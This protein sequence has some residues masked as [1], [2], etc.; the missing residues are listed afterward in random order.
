VTIDPARALV[1]A[2][3]I[4][5]YEYGGGMDL[6]GAATEASRFARW[7]R[8]CGVPRDRVLLACS[9]VDGQPAGVD[10]VERIGTTRREMED[11]IRH[12]G[13]QTGDLLLIFWCGHGVLTEEG[14]RALFT[15]DAVAVNKRNVVVDDLLLSLASNL[16]TGFGRQIVLIDA[17]ANFI[18]D[19]HFDNA[20][21]PGTL[22]KGNL[23]RDVEQFCY[24]SAAQGQIADFNRTERQATFSNAVLN[25]LET[26]SPQA[27]P[28]DVTA[29][30]RHIDDLFENLRDT[31]RDLRQRPVYRQVRHY[32]GSEDIIAPVSVLPVAGQ[33]Q[34]VLRAADMTVSQVHR[35]VQAIVSLPALD[36]SDGRH[37]FVAGLPGDIDRGAIDRLEFPDLIA[38]MIARLGM[39]PILQAL[40][41]Q[42]ATDDDVQAVRQV[43]ECWRRQ[44]LI[45]PVL[46]TF[47]AVTLQ[48]VRGAY[49]RAVPKDDRNSPRDLD[50]ALDH[51]AAY[52]VRPGEVA[53]LHRLAAA[54]EQVTQQRVP[55]EWYDMST[56]RLES[57]RQDASSVPAGCS[58]L[59]IDLRDPEADPVGLA[60]PTVVTGHLY[61]PGKGWSGPRL[62]QTE[63]TVEGARRGVAELI[64][65]A[66]SMGIAT[67]TVGLIV[68]RAALDSVPE[69]WLFGD[70]LEDPVPLWHEHPTVLHSAERLTTYK[71]RSRW[72]EKVQAIRKRLDNEVPEIMWIQPENQHDASAI[73]DAVHGTEAACSGL[74]FMP[75]DFCRDLRRDPIIA[76]IAG[77]APYALWVR[78][79]PPE[80]DT[81]KRRL[82]ELVTQGAFEDIPLRLHRIR[83]DESEALGNTLRLVWDEP[84]ALPPMGQLAG[85]RGGG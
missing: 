18:Q 29:L 21:P 39:R 27:L 17:C 79:E 50:E 32:T 75:G 85:M 80:W 49:F 70:L 62:L 38:G 25:W 81:V 63:A 67:F 1:L 64:E 24:Y 61:L 51:A 43:G 59:V 53:P 37:R 84:D 54:L 52:G 76:M 48:Q 55:D 78:S 47:G 15:S 83:R 57:L 5:K 13:R 77:G 8:G 42:A 34:D 73:R 14:K 10:T 22:P 7:A 44:Q 2:V 56:G 35:M 3:G 31:T 58:R 72:Q 12:I 19:M 82:L 60:W 28:P 45:A 26:H 33:L 71:A 69:S 20:F 11:A 41:A 9:T 68:P 36:T 40:R 74:G 23:R 46:R 66:Y 30:T 4:E 16:L 65:W 6:P